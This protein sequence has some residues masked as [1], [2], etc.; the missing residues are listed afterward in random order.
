[1]AEI[2]KVAHVP[3]CGLLLFL[4]L[5][6]HVARAESMALGLK[7]KPVILQEH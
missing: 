6:R 3:S 1:M 7:G 2:P 4:G 5:L